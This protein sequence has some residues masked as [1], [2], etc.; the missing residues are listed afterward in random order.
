MIF[1]ICVICIFCAICDPQTPN[2]GCEDKPQINVLAV[3]NGIKITKQDLSI[4]TRTQVDLV[5]DEVIAARNLAVTQLI[6]KTLLEAEAKRRGLTPSKLLE[7]EV[8]AKIAQP[9]DDEARAY[10]EQN[11]TRTMPD[12]KRAKNDMIKQMMNERETLRTREF[13]NSLRV[14]AQVN[15]SDQPVTPPTSEADLERVFATV[16]GANITSLDVEQGLLP[17][18][19]RVQKQVY[20]LRKQDLDLK[21][22]DLLLEQEAK[23][24]GTTASALIYQN[25]RMRLP[26]ITDDQARAF[27]HEHKSSFRG[28]FA[29]VKIQILQF[30]LQ[31]E[32]RKLVQAYVD[33]LRSNAAVQVYLIAPGPADLRQLC[34]NPVD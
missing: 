22:N 30:L 1:L 24:L 31:K 14:A 26:I 2:C 16:N 10:Y 15:V 5:Q 25:I 27:Y 18:I 29:A 4:D 17:I 7:L 13:A 9:T 6:N 3:V 11:K 20:E 33:Q 21:I 28:D 19:S 12:F 34:C 32:E 23:R 8:T